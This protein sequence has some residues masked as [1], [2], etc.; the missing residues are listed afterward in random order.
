[1]TFSETAF[2]FGANWQSFVNHAVDEQRV[3]TAVESL[4][5]LLKMQDLQGKSF[6]G[7]GFVELDMLNS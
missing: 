4:Q 2:A 5:Q 7:N 6:L 3:A 1:M